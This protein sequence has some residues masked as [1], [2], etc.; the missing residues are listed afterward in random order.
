MS[1][2][3]LLGFTVGLVLF[4]AVNLISAHLSSDC[5]L[6][7]VFG[8]GPCADDIIRAGWPLI[9]YEDGGFA[10]RHIFIQSNLIL[11][12]TIGV[13]FTGTLGWLFTRHLK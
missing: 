13:L 2:K 11:D 1:K 6:P 4:L 8:R 5:G 10:Y 3:F 12:M 7:A 9:F